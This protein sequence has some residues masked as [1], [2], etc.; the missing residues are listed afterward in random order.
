MRPIPDNAL[1]HIRCG[2]CGTEDVMSW[3]EYWRTAPRLGKFAVCGGILC[4]CGQVAEAW[5]SEPD[6]VTE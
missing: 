1:F 2:N 6:E 4:K 3:K 5:V